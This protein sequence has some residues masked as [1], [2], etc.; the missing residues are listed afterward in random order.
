MVKGMET[1]ALGWPFY[2]TA[3][4]RLRLHRV[5]NVECLGHAFGGANQV[6][7]CFR[8]G[9]QVEAFRLFRLLGTLANEDDDH[10][11]DGEHAEDDQDAP[12][13]VRGAWL[14]GSVVLPDVAG[15]QP[16]WNGRRRLAG[17][18]HRSRHG[19]VPACLGVKQGSGR[20]EE[21][22]REAEAG[23][24]VHLFSTKRLPSDK[25]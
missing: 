20:Q 6:G 14:V 3:R 23:V 16:A 21:E 1:S 24:G 19:Q 15:P 4:A 7:R 25:G 5:R 10:D 22:Q 8:G 13:L 18:R 9:R 2:Y 17:T 11:R 12:A